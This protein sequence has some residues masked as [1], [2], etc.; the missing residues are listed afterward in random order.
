MKQRCWA[1][2]WKTKHGYT[3]DPWANVS[4][5]RI[6]EVAIFDGK[7]SPNAMIV[8]VEIREVRT[9]AR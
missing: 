5:K 8:R 7:M 9:C 2:K 1:I 6:A 3:L 4:R